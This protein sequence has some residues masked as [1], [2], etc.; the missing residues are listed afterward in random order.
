MG[1]LVADKGFFQDYGRSFP[2]L[3]NGEN[4]V[5]GGTIRVMKSA[6]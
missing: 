6:S 5:R 3:E 2:G 4:G 1:A